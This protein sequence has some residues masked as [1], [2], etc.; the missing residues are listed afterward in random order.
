MRH[1]TMICNTL[2][3]NDKGTVQA[4]ACRIRGEE[5]GKTVKVSP[6]LF[7]GNLPLPGEAVYASFEEGQMTEQSGS[8]YKVLRGGS[9]TLELPKASTPAEPEAPA[10]EETTVDEEVPFN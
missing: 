3:T 10:K 8:N 7:R 6:H 2:F 9:V 1:E 4:V 5:N